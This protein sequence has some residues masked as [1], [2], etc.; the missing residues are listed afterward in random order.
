V[1]ATPSFVFALQVGDGDIL[2]I[3]PQAS[4]TWLIAPIESV[5]S[6]TESLCM[7]KAWQYVRTHIL[8]LGDM[9][10]PV[11]FLLSTD[12]YA[13]SFTENAGFLKAGQDIYNLW[14]EEGADYIKMHLRDWLLES[15]AKGSGDDITVVLAVI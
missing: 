3:S 5:G 13:N 8:P 7:D 14:R 9:Q 1:A 2:T 12:G 6:E 11:M 10:R 15:T 4:P